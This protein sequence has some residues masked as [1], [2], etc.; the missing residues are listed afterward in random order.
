[1][2]PNDDKK[3]VKAVNDAMTPQDDLIT[4]SSG[5][6]LRGKKA[7]PLT[8]IQVMTSYQRP[9]PP[10]TYIKAMGRE[11]ENPDDPNYLEELQAWKM[12]YSNGMV[13]AM[14]LLGT[15]LHTKP[16][17]MPG[18]DDNAWVEE[19]SLLVKDIHPENKS[20]RYLTWVKFKA[21][22]DE[23]DMAQVQEVVGRLSGVRENAV[24]AAEDFP[25][26]D[27]ADR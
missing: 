20:W 9:T 3:A 17:G 2:K 22:T 1:M 7:N 10:L 23:R 15:E 14:I 24:N 18:P 16:K 27:E 21:M 25:G 8:L 5:V 6:I 4:L 26:R 19:Y 11:M 12:A 13:T